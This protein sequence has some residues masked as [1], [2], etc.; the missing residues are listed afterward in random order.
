MSPGSREFLVVIN[1]ES[2]PLDF[3]WARQTCKLKKW[4]RVKLY[5]LFKKPVSRQKVIVSS[6]CACCCCWCLPIISNFFF[7]EYMYLDS[8]GF[9]QVPY[10][11][12]GFFKVFFFS[13]TCHNIFNPHNGEWKGFQ[14]CLNFSH[15]S[16]K[17]MNPKS[18][19]NG[20]S[21]L[22]MLYEILRD[23]SILLSTHPP[24]ILSS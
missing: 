24:I 5:I 19:E 13:L 2:A 16:P 6:S 20:T 9:L 8:Y 17:G 10:G 1:F 22:C 12:F 21:T 7:G 14:S 23:V 15:F 4:C 11:S 18:Q 3:Q